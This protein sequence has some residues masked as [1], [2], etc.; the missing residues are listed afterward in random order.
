MLRSNIEPATEPATSS[1]LPLSALNSLV[2]ESIDIVVHCTRG[3]D[4]PSVAEVVAVEDLAAGPDAAQFT[5]T[6]VFNR[7]GPGEPLR[8]TGNLPVRASRA[9]RDS[10]HDPRS[11]LRAHGPRDEV[12]S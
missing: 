5:V 11:L 1:D 9:L 3:P 10:A 12:E 4:G 8:W 6:D 2:S 7:T